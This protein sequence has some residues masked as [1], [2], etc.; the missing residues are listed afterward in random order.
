MSRKN[1]LRILSVLFGVVIVFL[2][3]GAHVGFRRSRDIQA[4][5]ATLVKAHIATARLVDELDVEQHR[6]VG[7]LVQLLRPPPL[8]SADGQN[9]LQNL[10]QRVTE[11]RRLAEAAAASEDRVAWND[12]VAISGRLAQR[13]RS[14]LGDGRLK[15][16]EQQELLDLYNRFAHVSSRLIETDAARATLLENQIEAE[17]KDWLTES[18]WLLGACL[19]AASACALV[20]VRFTNDSFRKMEWQAEELNRVSWHMLE[21][22]EAAARRFSH[23]MH[24]EL[25]QSLTGLKAAI[26]AIPAAEF[27]ARRREC[28]DLLDEA[29]GNV[30]ELSQ[31][32]RPVILDDFG[33]EAALRWLCDGFGERTR[34][35]VEYE[36]SFNERV[37]DDIET[38]L[39]RI[40][41]EAL[42]NVARHSGASKVAVSL[43]GDRDR[44]HLV[45][46][47]NGRGLTKTN[48]SRKPTL[49]MTGMR[50]RARQTGGELRLTTSEGGG[51][52]IE[53]WVPIRK[54]VHDNNKEDAHLVG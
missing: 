17:S 37:A 8:R 42:T 40:A 6:L 38:H 41:Q 5:V 1:V 33:L 3:A 53:V 39:F 13:A 35:Q 15:E 34:I 7:V 30:R 43:R 47:D 12:L 25:G 20:A 46:E 44:V 14:A 31:L 28:L 23:E 29:I 4:N 50:A 52:K 45:I 54:P 19:V 21:G 22:Q 24:D 9:I 26:S 10:D 36:S 51:V 32:L 2:A 27:V 16:D 18:A 48:G 49:G 11:I